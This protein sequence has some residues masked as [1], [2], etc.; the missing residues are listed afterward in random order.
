MTMACRIVKATLHKQKQYT[1]S[2]M[3]YAITKS[4]LSDEGIRKIYGNIENIGTTA[5]ISW[6]IFHE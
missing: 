1:S 3:P 4:R 2:C 5:R 6:N